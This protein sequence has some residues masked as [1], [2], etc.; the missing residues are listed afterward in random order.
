MLQAYALHPQAFTSSVRERA[1]MP[2]SWWESR[3][4]SKLDV[5]FG[6]FAY[7]N[8]VAQFCAARGVPHDTLRWE[9]AA[10]DEFGQFG[11]QPIGALEGIY[12]NERMPLPQVRVGEVVRNS[13]FARE[14]SSRI[15]DRAIAALQDSVELRARKSPVA[16]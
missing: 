5:V 1:A 12:A 7:R 4:S 13:I 9:G 11:G 10:A 15:L 2:L 8:A 6:A 14:K 16:A 3:L